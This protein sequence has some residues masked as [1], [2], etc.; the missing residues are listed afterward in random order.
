M[1]PYLSISFAILIYLCS[2][3]NVSGSDILQDVRLG[4]RNGTS[5]LQDEVVLA[6]VPDEALTGG[7]AL[8]MSCNPEEG[9]YKSCADFYSTGKC[10]IM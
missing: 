3:C 9:Q 4:G 1:M 6:P 2:A 10:H 8:Q 7:S 5:A